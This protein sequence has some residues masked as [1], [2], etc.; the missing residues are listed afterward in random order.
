MS[1]L[2]QDAKHEP[3]SWLMSLQAGSFEEFSSL[4]T[5]RPWCDKKL[6]DFCLGSTPMTMTGKQHVAITLTVSV[7]LSDKFTMHLT[8]V[9]MALC[10]KLAAVASQDS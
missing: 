2:W 5:S 9:A 6:L 10:Q 7:E 4:I 3:I 1:H 8:I